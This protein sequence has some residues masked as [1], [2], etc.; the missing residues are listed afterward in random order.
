[1]KRTPRTVELALEGEEEE[2]RQVAKVDV[3]RLLAL[4]DEDRGHGKRGRP[5]PRLEY[6]SSCVLLTDSL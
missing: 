4:A 2:E 3:E 5:Q 6:R 1:M